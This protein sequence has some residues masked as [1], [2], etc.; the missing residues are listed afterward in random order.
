MFV[1]SVR[2]GFV[3]ELRTTVFRKFKGRTEKK[4]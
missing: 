3:P 4:N 2:N 1:A